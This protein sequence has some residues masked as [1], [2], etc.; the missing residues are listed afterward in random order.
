MADP[1]WMA[2]ARKLIGL[3]EIPGAKHEPRIVQFFAEAGHGYV[4]DDE[5]SWCAAFANAMLKRVGIT[6]TGSLAAR[7]FLNWGEKLDRP[8]VGCIVVFWRGSPSSW[9]GHV[10]FYA[11]ENQT[12]IRV[13]GGNQSNAVN[14]SSY[15]KSQLLGYRWP[16]E[17]PK[18]IPEP[19]RGP[20]T[21]TAVKGDTW[22]GISQTFGIPLDE[23]LRLNDA[24]ANTVLKIGQVVRLKPA[25]AQAPAKPREARGLAALIV[26]AVAAGAMWLSTKICALTGLFCGG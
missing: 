11:G 22:W 15:P 25:A 23:L 7:S 10:G 14:I 12:H 19:I 9:Q 1:A 5:T 20:A 18:P 16:T 8:R 6:G 26:A 2:E 4:K 13:L 3:K 24:D 21:H 17:T